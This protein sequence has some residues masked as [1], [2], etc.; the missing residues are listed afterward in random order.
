MTAIEVKSGRA[1][2]ALRGLACFAA[3]FRPD[4]VLVVGS[5]GIPVAEFLASPVEH[6]LA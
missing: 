4:R 1:P 3:T 5:S 2:D 6:W